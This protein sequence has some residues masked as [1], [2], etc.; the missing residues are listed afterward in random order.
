MNAPYIV[1]RVVV[2]VNSFRESGPRAWASNPWIL[3][4][5]FALELEMR[6]RGGAAVSSEAGGTSVLVADDAPVSL[7]CPCDLTNKISL[8]FQGLTIAQTDCE[9]G[10]PEFLF[11]EGFDK[12]VGLKSR[13]V[14][15]E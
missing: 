2:K 11:Q 5:C 6:F 15:T 3:S 13:I 12:A 7:A 4:S 10:F 9:L 8:S 14:Q 1:I